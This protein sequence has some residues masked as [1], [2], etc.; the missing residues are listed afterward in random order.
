MTAL[1]LFLA[2]TMILGLLS[3]TGKT[4]DSRD[5]DKIRSWRL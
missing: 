5:H 4:T 1:A 3:L 2:I